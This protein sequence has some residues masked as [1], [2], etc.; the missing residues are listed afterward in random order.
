MSSM[1]A[2][3]ILQ[4][5]IHHWATLHMHFIDFIT[6]GSQ[7][8][9]SAVLPSQR[10]FLHHSREKKEP[11]LDKRTKI[12]CSRNY[13]ARVRKG[14][15]LIHIVW[16]MG[17]WEHFLTKARPGKWDKYFVCFPDGHV[18]I[19]LSFRKF[20]CFLIKEIL[21]YFKILISYLFEVC[22]KEKEVG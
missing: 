7:T 10:F 12:S 20:Y 14:N 13:R 22:L 6:V 21:S 15:I 18:N 3:F 1:W 16:F 5:I 9:R 8:V 19:T 2:R 4:N 11:E 17:N